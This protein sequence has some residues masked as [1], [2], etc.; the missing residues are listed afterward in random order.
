MKNI[1]KFP[2]E[3]IDRVGAELEVNTDSVMLFFTTIPSTSNTLK[4][5]LINSKYHSSYTTQEFNTKKEQMSTIFNTYVTQKIKE[6]SHPE[7]PQEW[8][9]TIDAAEYEKK[10]RLICI[11]PPKKRKLFVLMITN[12][13]QHP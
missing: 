1:K 9:L 10:W 7:F 12:T 8:K 5:M 11:N 6:I 2:S 13:G 3:V 4:N